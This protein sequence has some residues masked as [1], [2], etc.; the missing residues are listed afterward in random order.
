MPLVLIPF[1]PPQLRTPHRQEHKS[2]S[3]RPDLLWGPPTL[4]D[5]PD[6]Q[7]WGPW[8][9]QNMVVPI[10][11]NKCSLLQL[12]LH[13]FHII[14]KNMNYFFAILEKQISQNLWTP[15]LYCG[16]PGPTVPVV[17]SLIRPG[18]KGLF[19]W[20]VKC[21]ADHSPPSSTKVKNAWS[22]TSTSLMSLWRGA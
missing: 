8:G 21:E 22:S 16:G 4:K 18:I 9:N 11:K 3:F 6:L 12:F 10:S 13:L 1:C 14:T 19:S 7:S 15:F 2:S 17:A 20:G 5:R